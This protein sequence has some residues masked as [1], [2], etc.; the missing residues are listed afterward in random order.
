MVIGHFKR[1]R[2]NKDFEPCL[3][4]SRSD[5]SRQLVSFPEMYRQEVGKLTDAELFRFLG[6]IGRPGRYLEK[7]ET[8]FHH[9]SSPILNIAIEKTAEGGLVDVLT[10]SL[11]PVKPYHASGGDP[12]FEIDSFEAIGPRNSKPGF[13]IIVLHFSN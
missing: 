5:K 8:I 4:C 11:N 2:K 3:A 12:F 13:E 9:P 7:L 1:C 10:S 6:E